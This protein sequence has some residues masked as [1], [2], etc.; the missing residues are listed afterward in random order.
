MKSFPYNFQILIIFKTQFISGLVW[1]A[2]CHHSPG[3]PVSSKETG[4]LGGSCR[5]HCLTQGGALCPV[6]RKPPLSL[7]VRPLAE[8]ARRKRAGAPLRTTARELPST[9][10]G[11]T[12]GASGSPRRARW[13]KQF[14]LAPQRFWKPHC[15]LEPQLTN[16][17]LNLN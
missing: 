16:R 10:G 17:S 6:A 13:T 5:E 7:V 15:H 3:T 2:L 12:A 8:P 4:Q 9:A 11:D 1:R 14:K